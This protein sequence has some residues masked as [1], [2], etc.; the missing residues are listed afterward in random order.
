MSKTTIII[1]IIAVVG[2][3]GAAIVFG[4]NNDS[5]SSTSTETNQTTNQTQDEGDVEEIAD[6]IEANNSIIAL[7]ASNFE[8]SQDTIEAAPGDTVVI[9]LTV[10]SGSHDFVIDE[11][12]V[13]TSLL[14]PGETERI[15]FIIPEDAAGKTY[16]FYCSVGSHRAQGME[17]QLV[18]EG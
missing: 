2:L 8:Y 14:G 6:D 16:D 3:V 4:P 13:Q 10:E 9:D 17:G 11:L 1:I 15:E 18:I 5:D 12:D 7:T